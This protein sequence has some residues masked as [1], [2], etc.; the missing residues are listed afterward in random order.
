ML[1]RLEGRIGAG[2]NPGG[3][4]KGKSPRFAP[5]VT[6][7]LQGQCFTVHTQFFCVRRTSPLR[8]SKEFPKAACG[9]DG[10]IWRDEARKLFLRRFFH[11]ILPDGTV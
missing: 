11:W 6:G 5:A 7:V 9:L 3:Y 2:L 1:A 10:A 8:G 4:L